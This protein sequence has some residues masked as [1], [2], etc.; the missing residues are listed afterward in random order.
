M[1][2]LTKALMLCS[3]GSEKL[4]NHTG[5]DPVCK[6]DL[7]ILTEFSFSDTRISQKLSARDQEISS[8]D[9]STKK[10][11]FQIMI[12]ELVSMGVCKQT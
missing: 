9:Q 1:S 4:S 6:F 3:Q 11:S 12:G 10:L 8:S 2:G 7:W 5:L